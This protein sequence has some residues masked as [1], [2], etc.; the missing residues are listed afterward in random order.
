MNNVGLFCDL[1][2]FPSS[3]WPLNRPAALKCHGVAISD[4]SHY[5]SVLKRWHRLLEVMMCR[6]MFM[7]DVSGTAHQ[8]LL[9]CMEMPFSA[10]ITTEV[11]DGDGDCWKLW[12]FRISG[13]LI[14]QWKT[15]GCCQIMG[16]WSKLYASSYL[17]LAVE[18][19]CDKDPS[20]F[21]GPGDQDLPY[22]GSTR[23]FLQTFFLL[24][25]F[26]LDMSEYWDS[27]Q[28]VSGKKRWWAHSVILRVMR[29]IVALQLREAPC[30]MMAADSANCSRICTKKIN[31]R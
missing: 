15:R 9:S 23:G 27:H 7:P 28:H 12:Y 29:V 20:A 18:P 4:C 6:I 14:Q 22:L 1:E 25:C 13:K 24:P 16:P 19:S 31:G 17:I 10:L 8:K 21:T 5:C 2:R 30:L 11:G 3:S 26:D